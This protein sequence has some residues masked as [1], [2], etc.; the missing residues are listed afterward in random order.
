MHRSEEALDIQPELIFK[1]NGPIVHE[2]T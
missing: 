2:S 1:I